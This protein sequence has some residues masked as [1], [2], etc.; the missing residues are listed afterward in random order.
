[1]CSCSPICLWWGFLMSLNGV[2]LLAYLGQ[3]FVVK[4]DASNWLSDPSLLKEASKVCYQTAGLFLICAV[5]NGLLL[6][7]RQRKKIGYTDV[8][9]DQRR[10]ASPKPYSSPASPASNQHKNVSYYTR[11]P[12]QVQS[13]LAEREVLLNNECGEQ[14]KLRIV[15]SSDL[16]FQL[17]PGPALD[18]RRL[19]TLKR[20]TDARQSRPGR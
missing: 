16:G 20:S 9:Q 18:F 1:M 6:L 5:L 12:L 13:S 10:R 14:R 11:G 8:E 7:G 15:T 4:K 3:Q 19:L 17:P 2:I